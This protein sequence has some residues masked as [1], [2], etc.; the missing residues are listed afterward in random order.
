VKQ[1]R[2][3]KQRS[4]PHR[5]DPNE[6]TFA[7]PRPL[8]DRVKGTDTVLAAIDKAVGVERVK[9]YTVLVVLFAAAIAV[10]V[11]SMIILYQMR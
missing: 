5:P 4:Q 6:D 10:G 3:Y 9:D 2:A 1:Q 11:L 8:S 7:E